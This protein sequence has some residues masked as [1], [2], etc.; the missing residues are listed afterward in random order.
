MAMSITK[1]QYEDLKEYWDYQR[2]IEYNKEALKNM[3]NKFEG[4]VYN[5]FG[6]VSQEEVFENLWSKVISD[7]FED[8]PK[9]WIPKDKKYRFEWEGEPKVTKKPSSSKG[10][11]VILRAKTSENNNI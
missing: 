1:I 6:M 7:D 2:K 11:P 4:R 5:D 8:P 10:R 3:L 9:D